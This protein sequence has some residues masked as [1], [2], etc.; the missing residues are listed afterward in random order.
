VIGTSVPHFHM[1]LLARYPGTPA[2]LEWTPV[3]EWE[4]A[5]RGGEDAVADATARIRA[6]LH[7]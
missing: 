5:P 2:D 3:D 7:W 4:A 6:S 1:H